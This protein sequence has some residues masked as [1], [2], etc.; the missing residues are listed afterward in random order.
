MYTEWFVAAVNRPCGGT[1]RSHMFDRTLYRNS[2]FGLSRSKISEKSTTGIACE[3]R[4]RGQQVAIVESRAANLPASAL[5]VVLSS[6]EP[7]VS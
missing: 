4:R 2:E 3:S 1:R 7:K 5:Y 6:I